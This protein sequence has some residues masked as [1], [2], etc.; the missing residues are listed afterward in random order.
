MVFF[1]QIGDTF[2][3]KLILQVPNQ[4]DV[5]SGFSLKTRVGS[6]NGGWKE[7]Q[8]KGKTSSSVSLTEET[9]V[10]NDVFVVL[11]AWELSEPVTTTQGDSRQIYIPGHRSPSLKQ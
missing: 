11:P 8:E 2:S 1:G 4:L 9:W 7:G 3:S 5:G 6:E 10:Q